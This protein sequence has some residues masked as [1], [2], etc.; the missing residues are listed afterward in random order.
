MGLSLKLSHV[1]RVLFVVE[2]IEAKTVMSKRV[3]NRCFT[4]DG[5]FVLIK[6]KIIVFFF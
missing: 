6:F 4:Q 2:D 1:H 3:K 5:V